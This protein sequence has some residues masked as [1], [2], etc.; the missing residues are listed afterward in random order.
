MTTLEL[1]EQ[2]HI[3]VIYDDEWIA[4][5]FAEGLQATGVVDG[6]LTHMSCATT[7]EEAVALVVADIREGEG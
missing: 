1:M 6:N 5:V 2:Y 7:I 4:G 3:S